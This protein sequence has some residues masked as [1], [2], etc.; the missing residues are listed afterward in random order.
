MA[1]IQVKFQ[2][3]RVAE[4]KRLTGLMPGKFKINDK[5]VSARPVDL[6]EHGLGVLVAK[7]F[8]IGA[9]AVLVIKD[10]Q[11]PFEIKWCQ[12]DF[13]K[14]DLWRYGLVCNDPSLDLLA[15]FAETGC[16]K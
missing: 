9:Q 1:S 3:R 15:L 6:S 12:P 4:R 8:A 16:F 14:H 10:T 7:E 13:G 2:E 11:I 5:E